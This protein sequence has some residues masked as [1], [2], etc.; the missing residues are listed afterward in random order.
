[1]TLAILCTRLNRSNIRI[2]FKRKSLITQH[3]NAGQFYL[4]NNL[5]NV[6]LVSTY[7]NFSLKLISLKHIKNGC[8][9][10]RK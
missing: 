9:V 2:Y 1:M 4:P 7:Y 8:V 6:Y 5:F 10:L 3:V